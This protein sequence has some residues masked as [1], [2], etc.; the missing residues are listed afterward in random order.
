M[1][2]TNAVTGWSLTIKMSNVTKALAYHTFDGLD[3]LCTNFPSLKQQRKHAIPV[4]GRIQVTGGP[5]P[6]G[7]SQ[8]INVS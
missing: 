3:V 7:K 1:L 8:K 5:N 4:Q 2:K 6:L